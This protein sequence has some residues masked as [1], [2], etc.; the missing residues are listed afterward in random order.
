MRS[1]ASYRGET[2][3]GWLGVLAPY[4][5]MDTK[6]IVQFSTG[7]GSAECAYRVVA[8]HGTENVVL[9]T[10]DTMVEDDDNW[11]FAREVVAQLGC[12]WVVLRDGRTP[13][14]VGRSQRIVPNDRMAVCSRILK[15]EL[16]RKHL[17][18]NYDPAT[19][20]IYL[21]FDWTE[22]PRM[23]AARPHWEPWTI[24]A[25]LMHPPYIE[26]PA[27]LDLMRARGIEPPRLYALGFGHANCGGACVRG[28]QAAWRLLL[29]KLPERYAEWE[30]EEEVT[31]VM[32][33]KDV[34]I[35]SDRRGGGKR[36]P[37]TLKA[38]RQRE[39]FDRDYWGACGC[40]MPDAPEVTARPRI[41]VRSA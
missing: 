38:F 23:N 21:G 29:D 28:G 5:L 14:E 37:L 6:H 30:A 22:E 17:N 26:K 9:L 41:A 15:R 39:N 3:G 13:M 24:E 16:L 40:D 8:E 34:S 10:A 12:E 36:R 33:G 2:S 11:R 31:R 35:L 18:A 25:P 27:V 32:L 20:V 1:I 19:S 4:L 7:A